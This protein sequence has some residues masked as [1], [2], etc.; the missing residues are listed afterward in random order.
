MWLAV[1]TPK[2]SFP[3][4]RKILGVLSYSL[5]PILKQIQNFKVEIVLSI[6]T[7]GVGGG[8]VHIVNIS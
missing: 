8:D 1:W 3:C 5:P 4:S 2:K 6:Q 7:V